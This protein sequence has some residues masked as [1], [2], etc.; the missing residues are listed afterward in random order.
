M[1]VRF[2]LRPTAFVDAPFGYD[3]RVARLAGGLAWFSAVEIETW[4]DGKRAP[5]RL[6]PVDAIEAE[7]AALPTE[8]RT[9]LGPADHRRGRR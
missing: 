8:A 6:V 2:Y 1:A 9:L 7:L 5:P 3:G 4:E